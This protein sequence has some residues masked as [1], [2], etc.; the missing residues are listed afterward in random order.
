[1]SLAKEWMMPVAR[2]LTKHANDGPVYALGDQITWLTREYALRNLSKAGLLRNPAA[3]VI[4]SH[5]NPKLISLQTFIAMLGFNEYHDIDING[6]A[7]ITCDFSQPLPPQLS[8]KAGVVV[9]IGTCEHIFNLPQAFTNIVRLLRPGGVVLHLAPLSFYNHGFVNFNPI[10]FREFY[11]HNQFSVL[12]HGLIVAPIEYPLQFLLDRLGVEK[13]Y[14]ES[15]LSPVSFFLNDESKTV[16]RLAN[17]FGVG[18]RIIFLFAGRK[19]K[20]S[21]PVTFP[22]Q[23]IYRSVDQSSKHD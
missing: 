23:G 5:R 11:E 13:R 6:R 18:A 20:G 7:A 3:P 21:I 16:S 1:M 19:G 15:A 8:E 14:H 4:P 12:E 10:F 2:V 17:Y 22:C 9:D